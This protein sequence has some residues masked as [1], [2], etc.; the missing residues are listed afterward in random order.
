MEKIDEIES[1]MEESTEYDNFMDEF[2]PEPSTNKND[3]SDLL[4]INDENDP[5]HWKNHWK[6]MPE[7]DQNDAKEYKKLIVNFKTKEDYE[8]FAELVEQTL[9]EKTKTIW[10]PEQKRTKNAL[11]RWIVDE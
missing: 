6:D 1:P 7:Y 10:Y 8:K 3:L 4:G 9:T 5:D 11:L 2:E